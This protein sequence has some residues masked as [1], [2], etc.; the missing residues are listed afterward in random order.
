[1]CLW[2]SCISDNWLGIKILESTVLA[3]QL[4]RCL[5]R[6]LEFSVREDRDELYFCFLVGI[7]L[8]LPQYLQDFPLKLMVVYSATGYL[9]VSFLTFDKTCMS[10]RTFL[11]FF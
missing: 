1:M 3:S 11:K 10:Y 5:S 8:F 7:P 2:F 4:C 6:I 9:N